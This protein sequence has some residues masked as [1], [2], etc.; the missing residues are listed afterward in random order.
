MSRPSITADRQQARSVQQATQAS[1]RRRWIKRGVT[2]AAVFAAVFAL[3]TY[4]RMHPN[5]FVLAGLVLAIAAALW[6]CTDVW[7]QSQNTDWE[8]PEPDPFSARGADVRVAMLRRRLTDAT[9]EARPHDSL[10]PILI[11]V[12]AERLAAH[13]GIDLRTEPERARPVLGPQLSAYLDR[14]RGQ[15]MRYHRRQLDDLL[16]RIEDL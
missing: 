2:T 1:R 8:P 4:L 11:A 9:A 5:P 13:H 3:G 10:R 6:F 12:I 14:P 16:T 15:T 7:P